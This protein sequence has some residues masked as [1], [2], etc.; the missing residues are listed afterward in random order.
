MVPSFHAAIA[1]A[2]IASYACREKTTET[3]YRRK[4][5]PPCFLFCCSISWGMNV[6]ERLPLVFLEVRLHWFIYVKN[7][8]SYLVDMSL[9]C[10]LFCCSM[11]WGMNVLERLPLVFLEIRM[12]WFIYLKNY[13]SYLVA[14]P[15]QSCFF[16]AFRSVSCG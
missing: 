4:G 15:F 8:C 11:S 14:M 6:R 12:H 1:M 5:A 7:Y 10:F 13:C 3:H 16:F 2:S 9:P